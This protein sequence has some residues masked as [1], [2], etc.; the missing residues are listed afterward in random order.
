MIMKIKK[1]KEKK[2]TQNMLQNYTFTCI[3]KFM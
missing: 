2:T 1:K 3:N